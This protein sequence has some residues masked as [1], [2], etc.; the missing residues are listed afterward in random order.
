M[1][2][3]IPYLVIAA[4]FVVLVL[5]MIWNPLGFSELGIIFYFLPLVLFVGYK[6]YQEKNN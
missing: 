5:I 4:V 3:T 6:I 2:K 1:Q